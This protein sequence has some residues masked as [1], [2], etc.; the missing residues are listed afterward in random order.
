MDEAQKKWD[1]IV[2]NYTERALSEDAGRSLAISGIAEFYSK[3][4]E[5]DLPAGLMW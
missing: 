4:W 3:I 5:S 2:Q 1:K